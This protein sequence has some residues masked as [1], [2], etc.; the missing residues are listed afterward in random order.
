MAANTSLA[1]VGAG[2]WGKNLV[3]NFYQLGALKYICDIEK[4]LESG[5]LE[6]YPGIGF[7]QATLAAQYR[8]RHFV[9]WPLQAVVD[10]SHYLV[11]LQIMAYQI[12][13]AQVS[14][15]AT[16]VTGRHAPA[17]PRCLGAG[18][19]AYDDIVARQDQ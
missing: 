11:G 16:L 18:H 13:R 10:G 17:H 2:Y 15:V 7:T 14:A 12:T 1:I 4:S 8:R 6:K 19:V 5:Y 9:G 3:R